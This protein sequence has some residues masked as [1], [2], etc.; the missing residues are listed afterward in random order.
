MYIFFDALYIFLCYVMT[1]IM[2]SS[3]DKGSSSVVI[4]RVL[5]VIVI[6]VVAIAISLL[7][8]LI[9]VVLICGDS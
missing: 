9:L 5:Q 3:T 4:M 1:F 7:V 8:V 2:A 6:A